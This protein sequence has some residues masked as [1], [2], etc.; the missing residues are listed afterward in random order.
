MLDMQGEP[1]VLEA[2]GSAIALHG[3]THAVLSLRDVTAER[4]AEEDR[5]RLQAQLVHAQK[6]EGEAARASPDTN[7]D[8]RTC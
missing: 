8:S 4:R 7:R 1:H 3:T 5:K 2:R 6:M